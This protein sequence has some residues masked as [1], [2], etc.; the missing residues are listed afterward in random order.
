MTI[1]KPSSFLGALV[2]VLLVTLGPCSES[3]PP[4]QDP[5]R[6]FDARI[7][8]AYALTSNDNS[9][10]VYFSVTNVYD[11]TIDGQGVITGSI[12]VRSARDPNVKK[13]F[14]LTGTNVVSAPGFDRITRR[15]IV[16][17]GDTIRLGVSWDFIDD[18]GRDLR[19]DFFS[20]IED[21]TCRDFGR[22]LAFTEDFIL[23]GSV[24][25]YD[26]TAPVLVGPTVYSLWYVNK[27]V[28]PRDCPPI[29]TTAPCNLTPPQTAPACFPFS[30]GGD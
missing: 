18:A 6:L 27:W 9:M 3:L 23:Q 10:K 2:A 20:Y 14:S 19:R 12:E 26:R 24:R 11:E 7:D 1:A 25:L 30:T 17:P 13:T 29:I 22:C 8:G 15:L 28:L 21:M 16:D 4:Y 5:A